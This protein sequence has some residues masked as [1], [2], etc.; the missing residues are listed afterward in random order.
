MQTAHV[1]E[2]FRMDDDYG[3]SRVFAQWLNTEEEIDC[4][5][6]SCPVDCIHWV[7]KEQL[8]VRTRRTKSIDKV[9]VVIMQ[10]RTRTPERHGSLRRRLRV[11]SVPRA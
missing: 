11:P 9:S 3:R 6:A 1:P 7:Q 2:T 4:A 5:I 10:K 8:P